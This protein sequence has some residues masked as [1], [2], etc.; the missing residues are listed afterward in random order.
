MKSMKRQLGILFA[1]VTVIMMS[2]AVFALTGNGT[3]S[4]P[5]VV[6]SFSDIKSAFANGG[7]VKLGK[8]ITTDGST[9]V[10]EKD[11]S[12]E[13][14]GHKLK[15]TEYTGSYNLISLK[16]GTFTVNDSVGN[17][18][19]AADGNFYGIYTYGGKFILNSGAVTT[20]YYNATALVTSSDT[21]INGGEVDSIRI[22]PEGK[23][24]INNGKFGYIAIPSATYGPAALLFRNGEVDDIYFFGNDINKDTAIINATVNKSICIPASSAKFT[25]YGVISRSSSVKIDGVSVSTETRELK[26]GDGP[27][28]IKSMYDTVIDDISLNITAPHGGKTPDFLPTIDQSDALELFSG[29]AVKWYENGTEMGQSDTFKPGNTYSVSI[30]VKARSKH[31]I[32]RVAARYPISVTVNGDT[33]SVTNIFNQVPWEVVEI[34]YD[35]GTLEKTVLNHIDVSIQEPAAGIAPPYT[36]DVS[37]GCLLFADLGGTSLYNGI[38]WYDLNDERYLTPSDV[39]VAGREYRL[40]LYVKPDEYS[41]FDIKTATIN[42]KTVDFYGSSRMGY[43]VDVFKL[44]IYGD[45]NG[46]KSVDSKDAS[47]I[48]QHTSGIA[49][50][51]GDALKAGDVN[52][53]GNVDSKDASVILQYTS[54]IISKL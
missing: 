23:T 26:A 30:P 28:I 15:S 9:L 12:L 29:Q 13:L 24:V 48:L 35:F 50:L 44:P 19:I 53:D 46:D 5:Y 2:K 8:D 45:V 27:I 25:L 49:T 52:K 39:M 36:A 31:A 3:E 38:S 32:L 7:Y 17:G 21:V 16:N 37:E 1:A 51:S 6:S 18:G 43:V 47:L 34:T 4:S 41:A 14:D 40:E 11:V 22:I 42:G 10:I 33:A 54:G 20:D